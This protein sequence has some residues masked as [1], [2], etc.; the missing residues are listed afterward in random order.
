MI[1]KELIDDGQFTELMLIYYFFFKLK[2]GSFINIYTK[3]KKMSE[4]FTSLTIACQINEVSKF[5]EINVY[6]SN[7]KIIFLRNTD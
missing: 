3:R 4:R 6:L 1:H 7:C 5:I 2:L